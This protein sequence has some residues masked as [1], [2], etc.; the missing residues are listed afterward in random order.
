MD[1]L[2]ASLMAFKDDSLVNHITQP[3]IG[4]YSKLLMKIIQQTCKKCLRFFFKVKAKKMLSCTDRMKATWFANEKQL[5]AASIQSSTWTK[6]IWP[7]IPDG[8]FSVLVS[9]LLG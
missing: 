3:C 1:S 5:P 8:M 6:R 2:Q 9:E 7:L 4:S